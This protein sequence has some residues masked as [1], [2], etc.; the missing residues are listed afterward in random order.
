MKGWNEEGNSGNGKILAEL[1][2]TMLKNNTEFIDKSYSLIER[3]MISVY[4]KAKNAK[5]S[6][7]IAESVKLI[8]VRLLTKSSD[9]HFS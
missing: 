8:G 3:K 4:Q 9:Y 1:I 7:T 2:F 6:D 5:A